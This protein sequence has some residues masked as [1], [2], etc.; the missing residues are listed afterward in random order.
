MRKMSVVVSWN[1]IW[2]SVKEA[3]VH[4][5]G[6]G[7]SHDS[8][9]DSLDKATLMSPSIQPTEG[10]ASGRNVAAV[11]TVIAAVDAVGPIIQWIKDQNWDNQRVGPLT[12]S[13]LLT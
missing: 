3:D 11:A 8:D 5:G 4:Q 1:T 13:F 9:E 10:A 2:D 7:E 12:L 6:R